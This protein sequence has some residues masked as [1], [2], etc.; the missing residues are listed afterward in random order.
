MQRRYD[1]PPA[2][3]PALGFLDDLDFDTLPPAA[4]P[5]D[6]PPTAPLLAEPPLAPPAPDAAPPPIVPL[7][8]EVDVTVGKLALVT[9][10]LFL[11][12]AFGAHAG[13][14]KL[15]TAALGSTL[16]C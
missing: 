1:A 5:A 13:N 9:T 8:A 15:R 6:A 10:P 7:R 14:Q 12:S 4:P 16:L 3:P 2:A 11:M